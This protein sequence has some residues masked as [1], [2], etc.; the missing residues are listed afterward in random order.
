[1]AMP[2]ELV[3]SRPYDD[4]GQDER[5]A[6]DS[7]PPIFITARFRSGSTLLWNLFRQLEGCTA[8]YEPLN[9]RRWFDPASRGDRIDGTHIGVSDY[10]REYEG[11][12]R[13]GAFY[14]EAWIRQRLYMDRTSHEPRLQAY[15]QA[16]IDAAPGRAVLQF[17]RVDFRLD[18]LRRTFPD[19]RVI[20]LFRHPRDQWCSSLV[21]IR[22][23]PSS[24]RKEDFAANDHFYLL[25]WAQDLRFQFPFIDLDAVEHPYQLFYFIWKL[26]YV[27]GRHYSHG[28]FC[29]EELVAAPEAQLARLM[30]ASNI[31]D[32]DPERLKQVIV[33][34]K[35]GKWRQYATDA[36]FAAHEAHCER[37][38]ADFFAARC[39]GPEESQSSER[40]R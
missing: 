19:A 29:F 22:S 13:L 15:I 35:A 30:G 38:L 28:S 24:A 16:L 36:W 3:R 20:H 14:D 39:Q 27:F 17:N 40:E 37:I 34:Q 25:S 32:Y 26:S 6:G 33:G 21:D 9:E 10:W 8:Y 2:M 11:L 12:A 31:D 7:G 1:M 5:R 18:W 4:L 23:F